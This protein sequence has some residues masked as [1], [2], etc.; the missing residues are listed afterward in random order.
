MSI[1][2]KN[3][4]IISMRDL[5]RSDLDLLVETAGAIEEGRIKPDMAGRIAALLFFE[6]ST[7]TSFSFDSAMKRMGGET[8]LMKGTGS[9]SVQKG[10]SFSDTLRTIERYCD[11]IVMRHAVEGAARF[12]SEVVGLP[13]VNAGDGANQHPTQALLDLYSIKKTHGTLEKL[14]I[15]LVG[16]LRF[17]RTVH[18]LAQ[19]L[20]PYNPEFYFISPGF[21]EMPEHIKAELTAGG[22]KYTELKE[23][24]SVVPEL[25]IMYVTRV[26][27]ERFADPEDYERL[28]GS[29]IITL[30][31]IK[32]AKEGMRIL[33]PLP[34]VDEIA[35][36]VDASPHAY[37]FEQ[38]ENGVYM[39][40][41]ILSILT[42]AVK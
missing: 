25:D 7:R 28:K 23:V 27:R 18:S 31:T 16:D 34:R 30:D 8:L 12:A 29:Y 32:D 35:E 33:H 6:P 20:A 38:A 41:A 37:Y 42:G 2:L 21:L 4:H 11:I 15:G 19:A 36:E 40:Q 3:K 13:V 14:K 1:G 24:D 5:D 9:T 10:E 22:V 26:Q 39:R 17:G